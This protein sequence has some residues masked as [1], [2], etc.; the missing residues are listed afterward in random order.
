MLSDKE[1]KELE[2]LSF[3]EKVEG[4]SRGLPKSV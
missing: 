2:F 4:S 1:L 3:K